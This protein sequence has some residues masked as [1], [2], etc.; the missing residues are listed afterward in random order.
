MAKIAAACQVEPSSVTLLVAPTASLA[1][2]VQVVARSVETAMHKLAELKFDLARIV[3]AHGSAPLPPVAG[4]D[5]AAIGRTNDAILYGAR[6][7]LV[8]HRR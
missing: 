2:G 1:G 7:V 4:D 5:L 3:S 8:R 6:V